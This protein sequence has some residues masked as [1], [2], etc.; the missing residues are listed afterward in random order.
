MVWR[1]C[2]GAEVALAE[3]WIQQI[4]SRNCLV[5]AWASVLTSGQDREDPGEQKAQIPTSLMK[6][7]WRIC[8]MG[9]R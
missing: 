9:R 8:T 6:S 4:Y 5:Q 1:A 7:R 3:G 2:H